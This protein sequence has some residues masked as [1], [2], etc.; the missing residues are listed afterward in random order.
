MVKRR[1]QLTREVGSAEYGSRAF[2]KE[3]WKPYPMAIYRH[4]KELPDLTLN[5]NTTNTFTTA[6]AGVQT[7]SDLKGVFLQTDMVTFGDNIIAFQPDKSPSNP[8]TS[9]YFI[10]DAIGEMMITNS[11]N[12]VP[13][14][15]YV[16]AATPRRPLQAAFMP[17][18]SVASGFT[19]AD[20]AGGFATVGATPFASQDFTQNWK[21]KRIWELVLMAGSTFVLRYVI[22]RN[23]AFGESDIDALQAMST[24]AIPGWT[25]QFFMW[26]HGFPIENSGATEA[27]TGLVKLI[28]ITKNSYRYTYTENNQGL[29]DSS[30]VLATTTSATA[31]NPEEG[32]A[33]STA[34]L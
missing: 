17:A 14:R 6:T 33:G 4:V 24:V 12:S 5:Q 1:R 30:N 18:L 2:Y 15:L 25:T 23:H 34:A 8:Q 26:F 19:D 28:V 21:V 31:I 9:M 3:S 10:R 11:T 13:C 16:A 22:K 7:I 32:V 27:T 20:A 29:I